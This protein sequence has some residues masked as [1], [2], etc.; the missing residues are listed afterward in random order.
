MVVKLAE[1]LSAATMLPGIAM[2][3]TF[4]SEYGKLVWAYMLVCVCSIVYH[5]CN[6]YYGECN[7]HLLKLDITAQQ[8]HLYTCI[9]ITQEGTKWSLVFL[10]LILLV[11]MFDVSKRDEEMMCM[12]VHGLCILL[13]SFIA[14]PFTSVLWLGAMLTYI[15]KETY[16]MLSGSAWHTLI[17]FCVVATWRDVYAIKFNNGNS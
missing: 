5:L 11:H 7:G 15:M 14:N 9:L 3:W 17:H 10:P 4:W 16:P 1:L 13:A 6:A 8:I 2:A 12:V